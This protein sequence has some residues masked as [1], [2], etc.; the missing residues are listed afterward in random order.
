MAWSGV[1]VEGGGCGGAGHGHGWHGRGGVP[2]KRLPGL[3][4]G[5]ARENQ[6]HTCDSAQ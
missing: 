4:R 1:G 3:Y 5:M 6:L 2:V